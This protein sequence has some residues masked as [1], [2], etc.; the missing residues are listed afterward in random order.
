MVSCFACVSSLTRVA[1]APPS[2]VPPVPWTL[3][4][5]LMP[6]WA[7]KGNAQM[8]TERNAR[9]ANQG[10]PAAVLF[11]FV[12]NLFTRSMPLPISFYELALGTLTRGHATD[13]KSTRLN[14]SHVEI[15]YAV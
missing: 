12:L 15:S 11:A 9:R 2:C 5:R 10:P 4:L 14:S 8:K 3:P 1:F 7:N 6:S 13:R